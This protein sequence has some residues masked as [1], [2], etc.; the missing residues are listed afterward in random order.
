M[1]LCKILL[2]LD[3]EKKSHFAFCDSHFAFSHFAIRTKMRKCDSAK[4]DAFAS[5][6]RR[7]VAFALAFC[8]A[9]AFASHSHLKN[10]N[11]HPCAQPRVGTDHLFWMS[12]RVGT[13]KKIFLMVGSGRVG[14]VIWSV[15]GRNFLES[16]L[17]EIMIK[18]AHKIRKNYFFRK[19]FYVVSIFHDSLSV[20]P[21]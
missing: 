6:F 11:L 8:E 14:S 5:R 15:G 1:F 3:F 10:A 18:I 20:F 13:P 19:K 17:P 2:V 7:A 16:I 4:C 12:G 21:L 9:V